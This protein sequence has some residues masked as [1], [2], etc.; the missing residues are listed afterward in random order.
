MATAISIPD[1]LVPK[2]SEAA[3]K[4]GFTKPDDFVARLIEEK[5]LELE[6]QEKIFAITD[7][8]RAALEA[9]GISEEETLADFE[10]FRQRLYHERTKGN[11]RG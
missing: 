7:K 9:K 11:H 1:Q 6:E 4:K 8:V 10:K 5:L 3:K 2:I